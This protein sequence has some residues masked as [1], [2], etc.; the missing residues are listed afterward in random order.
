MLFDNGSFEHKR[1]PFIVITLCGLS[2]PILAAVTT[3]ADLAIGLIVSALLLVAFAVATFVIFPLVF[4][5]V[6]MAI[7]ITCMSW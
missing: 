2:A 5:R 4:F 7:I 6:F 1:A 3:Y